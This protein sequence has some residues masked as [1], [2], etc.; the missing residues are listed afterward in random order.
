MSAGQVF[1]DKAT[2]RAMMRDAVVVEH[3]A[4]VPGSRFLSWGVRALPKATNP[5]CGSAYLLCAH[6][7]RYF[8]GQL[9]L[10]LIQRPSQRLRQAAEG[11]EQSFECREGEG[12]GSVRHGVVR[13]GMGLDQ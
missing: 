7:P 5:A 6:P 9:D 10:G 3:A 1:L 13:I 2:G 11:F 8:T 12:L 4:Q